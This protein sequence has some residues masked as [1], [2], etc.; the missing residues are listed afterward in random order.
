[1][2]GIFGYIGKNNKAAN[3]VLEGIKTLE[4]RGYDSWGI[5]VTKLKLKKERI[6]LKKKIGEIGNANVDELLP[7]NFALGHTRW[8]THGGITDAN[9]H[10]HLDCTRQ[11]ALIH[12]GIIEN[13]DSLKEELIILGHKFISQTDSEVAIHLIEENYKNSKVSDNTGKIIDAVR[14]SFQR[15]AGLNAIIVMDAQNKVFI[16]AKNGSP[17]VIGKGKDG[18]F[19]ASDGHALLAHTREVCLPRDR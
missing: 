7:S 5:A 16:A 15:F 8:A 11:F 2:C 19:L 3:I 14:T 6:I 18:N 13:Y 12:N 1:M 10:P 17:L 4:Y 9:A